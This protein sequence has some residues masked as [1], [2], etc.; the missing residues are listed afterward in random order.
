M[1]KAVINHIRKFTTFE[2]LVFIKVLENQTE[3]ELK[4]IEPNSIELYNLQNFNW[5]VILADLALR[6]AEY[7]RTKVNFKQLPTPDDYRKY[8]SLYLNS[9]DNESNF[10]KDLNYSLNLALS[11]YG[12]EQMKRYAPPVNDL[13]RLIKLYGG[14]ESVFQEKFGLL[15]KQAVYFYTLNN[16]KHEIYEPFDF[17]NMLRLLQGY[18]STIT[19]NRLQTFLNIFS[20]TIKDY[21]L[22]AKNEGITKTTVKSKRLIEKY[23]IICLDKNYL[24]FIP[25]IHVLLESLSHKI[26][27]KLKEL[28]KNSDAFQRK[29]GDVF[30]DYIRALTQF[31]HKEHFYECNQLI[32]ED[33]QKKAEFYLVKDDI[34][35]IVEAKLLH[36]DEQIILNG[37]SVDLERKFKNTIRTAVEQIQS[38]FEKIDKGHQYGL[39]VI[40]THIPLLETYTKQFEGRKGFDFLNNIKIISIIDYEILIHNEI[41]SIFDYLKQDD[42]NKQQIALSFEQRNPFCEQSVLDLVDELSDKTPDMLQ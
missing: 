24:Y 4:K 35:I 13:G 11:K 14:I 18:D 36:I 16:A 3:E 39:I 41:E 37:S 7:E 17:K 2:W 20:I 15:P 9:S 28:Q 30:E 40:H 12:Y 42:E 1:N 10:T 34:A 19:E 29:F 31:S 23:P 33:H 26:F 32:Q 27:E 6:L 38:C 5:Y 21:R 8:I 22:S 25:S